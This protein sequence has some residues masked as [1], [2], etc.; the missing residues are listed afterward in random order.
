MAIGIRHQLVGLLGRGVEADGMV[1]LV[2]DRKRHLGVGAIDR[3]R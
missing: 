1:G 2:I 3:R